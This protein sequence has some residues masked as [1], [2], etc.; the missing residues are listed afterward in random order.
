MIFLHIRI[1]YYRCE[2]ILLLLNTTHVHKYTIII[3]IQFKVFN[4]N[5]KVI[6][7]CIIST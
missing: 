7:L 2:G 6:H 1:V 3:L 5:E 4:I